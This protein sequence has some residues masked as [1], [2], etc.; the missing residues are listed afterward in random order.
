MY[1]HT[2]APAAGG[3]KRSQN[4]TTK[5]EREREKGEA[6]PKLGRCRVPCGILSIHWALFILQFLIRL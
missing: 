2:P 5:T 6:W 3:S 4:K 1:S